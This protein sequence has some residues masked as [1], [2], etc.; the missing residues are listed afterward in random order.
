M[1]KDTLDIVKSFY[2][3]IRS[4]EEALDADIPTFLGDLEDLED[5]ILT[6][7]GVPEDT[8]CN[9]SDKEGEKFYRTNEYPKEYY[10][11]DYIND[12]LIDFYD[13]KI[14][15]KSFLKKVENEKRALKI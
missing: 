3:H 5:L 15:K 11:R 8:T 10:C 4:L 7:L 2:N 14:S 1:K 13:G 9:Y 12:L 6:D